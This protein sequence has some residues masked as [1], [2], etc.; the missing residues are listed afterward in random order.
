MNFHFVDQIFEL[1][2]N[3]RI[4]GVKH[5][6]PADFYLTKNF[7][8]EKPMLMSCIVGEA[9]GQLCSWNI[10]KSS[11]GKLRS[12]AGLVSEVR[13]YKPAY[14]GDS[15]FLEVNIEE[16]EE[17]AVTWNGQAKIGGEVIL[18]ICSSVGPCLPMDDFNHRDEVLQHLAWLEQR[19]NPSDFIERIEHL[20]PIRADI[21]QKENFNIAQE[22]VSYENCFKEKSD[23]LKI[24]GQKNVSILAP[25]FADHFP[26][27][28]VLPVSILLQSNLQLGDLFL[29]EYLGR[30]KARNYLP[31]SVSRIKIS[32]F[33]QPG[34]SVVTEVSLKEHTQDSIKLLFKSM[35]NQKRFCISE[36]EFVRLEL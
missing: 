34:D 10:I 32:E 11:H 24:I 27:K 6:T 28:P 7:T 13:M 36:V 20:V 16:L 21:L 1:E 14:L 9:L 18:E 29:V 23:A 33:I 22:L 35:L 19:K 12:V 3:K 8:S 17:D 31:K 26:K 2:L 15:I 5:V 4:T 25:Y 30:E